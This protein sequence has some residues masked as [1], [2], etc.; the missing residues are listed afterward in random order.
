MSEIKQ[1]AVEL[2]SEKKMYASFFTVR[3]VY[4]AEHNSVAIKY[5]PLSIMGKGSICEIG[6]G[7]PS[8]TIDNGRFALNE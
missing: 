4:T 3:R 6:L 2:A 1:N 8:W 5:W 7:N